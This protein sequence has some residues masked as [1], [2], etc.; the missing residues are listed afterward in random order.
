A[1]RAERRLPVLE[2]LVGAR[3]GLRQSGE[4]GTAEGSTRLEPIPETEG[5]WL[6]IG[7]GGPEKSLAPGASPGMA[8]ELA[9]VVG[10]VLAAE[11]DA[12]QVAAEPSGRYDEIDL[13]HTISEIP[14]HTI[15]LDE[16][17]D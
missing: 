15:R 10:S 17:A 5:F 12:V 4:A 7:N 3:M 13:I 16:A 6:E 2:R 14:G 8:Q 11:R 1:T 9:Q